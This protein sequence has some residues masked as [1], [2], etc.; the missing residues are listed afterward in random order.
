VQ[1]L[2][3]PLLG[4][5]IVGDEFGDQLFDHLVPHPRDLFRHVVAAHQFL[6]LLV[7]DL[8]LVVHHVVELQ[9]VL[10]DLE[11]AGLDALLRLLERLVD[12]RMG[13]RLTLLKAEPLQHRIHAVGGE[14]AHEIV[15]ERQEELGSAGVALAAGAAAQL[16]VD[17]AAFMPLGAMT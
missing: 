1:A 12:P 8:A 5:G 17:A 14:D 13:D 11:V 2:G 7:D 3:V 16:I 15:F 10:A 9:Q 4:I 6:A